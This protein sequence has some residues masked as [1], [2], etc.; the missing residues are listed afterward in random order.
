MPLKNNQ[1]FIAQSSMFDN[2]IKQSNR[3]SQSK[4]KGWNGKLMLAGV[5]TVGLGGGILLKYGCSGCDNRP[6]V[7]QSS[8][9]LE[10]TQHTLIGFAMQVAFVA[11]GCMHSQYH[12]VLGVLGMKSFGHKTFDET[13]KQM[14]MPVLELIRDQCKEAKDDMKA[15]PATQVVESVL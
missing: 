11:G 3:T 10:Q 8:T 15:L 4:T 5:R 6:L 9:L 12:K 14:S 7:F 13:I 1:V 2:F